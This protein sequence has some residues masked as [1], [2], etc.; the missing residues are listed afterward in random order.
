MKAIR[1]HQFGGPEALCYEEAPEPQPGEG[2]VLIR[3]K[4][5]GVNFA[6]LLMRMGAYP[7]R[8]LPLVPGLEA[9]GV[10]ETLGP[11]VS[12]L[13]PGQRVMAWTRRSYAELVAAP[14]W[15][16]RPAPANLSF[17][18][19]AAI[20]LA[21]GTSWHALVT[22]ARVQPGERVLVHAAGSGVG[23]AAIQLARQ[24]GAWVVATAGQDWKLERARQLGADATINYSTQDVAAE[25]RRLTEGEGVHVALEGVGKATFPASVRSL[26]M[27]GRLVIYGSPSGARVELDTREA[28]FRNLTLY[29]MAVTTSPRFP[30]SVE[31]FARQALPWFEQGLLA[32]V[33][34]RVYPLADAAQ[35]HQR[36]LERAQFGKLVLAV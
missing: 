4:A 12:G 33:V 15:G 2:E 8:D 7:S 27:E 25:V 11:G 34:D 28:I 1:I 21:F 16:V 14:A 5:V 31:A 22:L 26:G 19:A 23:S 9:A 6:D 29:G 24:L 35:A 10:V 3:V 13:Q 30:E 17:E 18:Q 36:V 20:P 32:P